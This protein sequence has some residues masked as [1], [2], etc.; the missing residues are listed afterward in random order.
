[1]QSGWPCASGES[2]PGSVPGKRRRPAP[3][4]RFLVRSSDSLPNNNR[5]IGHQGIR[6]VLLG[7]STTLEEDLGSTRFRPPDFPD[8]E[9]HKRAILILSFLH[10]L[11]EL[12][13]ASLRS[14]EEGQ[15]KQEPNKDINNED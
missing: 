11:C 13:V 10:A 2:S 5:V 7:H 14:S 15:W 8:E 6:A 9:I 4:R 12:M 1:C 3:S